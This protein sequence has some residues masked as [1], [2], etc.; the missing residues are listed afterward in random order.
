VGV[1]DIVVETGEVEEVEDVKS[2]RVNRENN[3]IW[4]LKFFK[5]HRRKLSQLKERDGHKGTRSL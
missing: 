2:Q 5:N 1:G 3:K 4:C